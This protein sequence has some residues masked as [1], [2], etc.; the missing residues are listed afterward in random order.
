MSEDDLKDKLLDDYLVS[1]LLDLRQDEATQ[2][3][4]ELK[5]GN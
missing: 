5:N 2:L 1:S 4:K 3:I